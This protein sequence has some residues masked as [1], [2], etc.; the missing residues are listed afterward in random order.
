MGFK[1]L[2]VAERGDK[3]KSKSKAKTVGTQKGSK[4]QTNNKQQRSK[5][6]SVCG[7]KKRLEQM[8]VIDP[9]SSKRE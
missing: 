9:E 6:G 8:A 1:K 4:K 5:L 7:L 2:T 3:R